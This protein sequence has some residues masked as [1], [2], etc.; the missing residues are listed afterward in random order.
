MTRSRIILLHL[1]CLEGK[2]KIEKKK[3]KIIGNQ[4]LILCMIF[5]CNQKFRFAKRKKVYWVKNEETSPFT[6]R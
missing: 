6:K 1:L 4:V 5:E 2:K 3:I